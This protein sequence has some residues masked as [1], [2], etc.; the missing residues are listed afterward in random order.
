MSLGEAISEGSSVEK[1]L[2]H[3]NG[4]SNDDSGNGYNGVDT[5]VVYSKNYGKFNE[6]AQFAQS[7]SKITIADN[8]ALRF[9]NN[10][11]VS[12]WMYTT[13]TTVADHSYIGKLRVVAG[14]YTGFIVH[15]YNPTKKI[16]FVIFKGG[17]Q[18]D[19]LYTT[20]DTYANAWY[21]IDCVKQDN[22]MKIYING[23]LNNSRT[24]GNMQ[25]STEPL[26]I[27]YGYTSA[28]ADLDEVRIRTRALSAQ[29]IQKE[30]T[31]SLGR[32]AIL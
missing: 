6:G 21:R 28:G 22:S 19:D 23:M 18:L 25:Y 11:T 16:G 26:Y 9:T 12:F 3:L 24:C 1:I 31:N 32:F 5:N 15:R 4:N 13:D 2:L 29:E 17:T 27:G 10:F 8:S 14:S 20:G 30:Y 7:N